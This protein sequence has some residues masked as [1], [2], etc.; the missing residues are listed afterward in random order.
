VV[1]ILLLITSV[2]GSCIN[3]PDVKIIIGNS[4]IVFEGKN[5]IN[6]DEIAK[7]YFRLETYLKSN[8]YYI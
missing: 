8:G 1:K 2:V 5:E 4:E 6:I 3:I 7:V